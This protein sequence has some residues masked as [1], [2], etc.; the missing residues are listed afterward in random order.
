[1]DITADFH[2]PEPKLSVKGSLEPAVNTY[3]VAVLRPS[4]KGR[5]APTPWEAYACSYAC[6]PSISRHRQEGKAYVTVVPHRVGRGRAGER[7]V[8]KCS[9]CFRRLFQVF[10]RDVSKVDLGVAYVAMA[11]H[12]FQAHISSGSSVLDLCCKCFIWMF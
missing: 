1:M 2:F 12:M 8:F 11:T 6:V 5:P 10:Y 9:K 7:Y 4:R 3:S